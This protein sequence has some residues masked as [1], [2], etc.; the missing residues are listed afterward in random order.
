MRNSSDRIQVS[1]VGSLPRTDEL[2]EANRARE[3]GGE[4][5]GFSELLAR[6]VADIV[7]RQKDV[8]VT[9][10][11]DGEYGHAMSGAVDYGAWWSYS[12]H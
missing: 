9:V 10:P 12:F 7:Q 2:I 6:S 1:H 8:G 4:T 11:N 5:A 3:E